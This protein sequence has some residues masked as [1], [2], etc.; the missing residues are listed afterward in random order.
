VDAIATVLG[1]IFSK[2]K[3]YY[4]SMIVHYIIV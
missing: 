3:M 1:I 2:S 4:T